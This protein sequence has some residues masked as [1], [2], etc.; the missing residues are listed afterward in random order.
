MAKINLT[1]ETGFLEADFDQIYGAL[2]ASSVELYGITA[3][4][5]TTSAGVNLDTVS[6]NLTTVSTD[7]DT[8]EASITTLQADVLTNSSNIITVTADTLTNSSN[9]ITLQADVLANSSAIDTKVG[10]DLA[11][12]TL[13]NA[14]T[15]QFNSVS[16]I[17]TVTSSFA[18][19]LDDAQEQTVTFT[20][21]TMTMTLNN[22]TSVGVWRLRMVNGG[23]ATLTYAAES[24]TITW[25]EGGTAP[26]LTSSGTDVLVILY[27][28]TNYLLTVVGA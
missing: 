16:S 2:V 9:I 5:V 4:S 3:D 20:A 14:K 15:I 22:P 6:A 26:T 25:L 12:T 8:A 23:L 10:N 7:L 21:N 24:G 19:E 11:N 1:S 27:D 17:G 13:D 18:V 28:G